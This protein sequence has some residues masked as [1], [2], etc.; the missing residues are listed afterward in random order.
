[1]RF[2]AG[3]DADAFDFAMEHE[4]E[5]QCIRHKQIIGTKLN[6]HMNG[7]A[8]FL[9]PKRT[10]KILCVAGRDAADKNQTVLAAAVAQF[11]T[12]RPANAVET[13]N[14]DR[15]EFLIE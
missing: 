3:H 2:N 15:R 7:T 9:L 4:R 14:F 6:V 13:R 8:I 12:A 5:L 1:M 11:R 10:R